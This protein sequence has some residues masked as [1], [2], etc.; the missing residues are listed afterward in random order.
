MSEATKQKLVELAELGTNFSGWDWAIVAVYL[1][2]TVVIGLYVNRY[3]RNMADYVVAGRSLKSFIAIASFAR[4]SRSAVLAISATSASYSALQYR[5]IL[6]PSQAFS[7]EGI[8]EHAQ[9]PM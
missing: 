9:L 1:A 7:G 5:G 3:I 2:G 8:S 4:V 6:L